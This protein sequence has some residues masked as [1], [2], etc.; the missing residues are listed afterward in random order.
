MSTPEDIQTRK[1]M[2]GILVGGA[3]CVAVALLGIGIGVGRLVGGQADGVLDVL[4]LAP[5][6]LLGVLGIYLV[7]YSRARTAALDG[8]DS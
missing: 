2:G 8:T 5:S 1:T 7:R 3:V 6:L 4:Q